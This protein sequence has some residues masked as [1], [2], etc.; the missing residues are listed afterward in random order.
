MKKT[1]LIGM[2]ALALISCGTLD[3]RREATSHKEIKEKV[4]ELPLLV[5]KADSLDNIP[6]SNRL[7][8]VTEEVFDEN[9]ASFTLH[10][11]L[12]NP[13]T[14]YL[15]VKTNIPLPIKVQVSFDLKGQNPDDTYIGVS[16][17]IT[18]SESP[19]IYEMDISN[20][21]VFNK[22]LPNG[23][24]ETEVKFYPN[25]G[26]EGGNKLAKQ[27]KVEVSDKG[28]NITLGGSKIS[29]KEQ[30]ER[31]KMQ[32]WVMNNVISS[33]VWDS[34]KF[35]QQLGSFTELVV[36]NR[37]SRVIKAYYFTKADMTIF[38]NVLKG[39]VATWRTGKEVTI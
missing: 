20:Y 6:V 30:G 33:T 37:N 12:K 1:I 11:E 13:T 39:K 9:T 16:E 31:D 18:L 15:A 2:L 24:Y 34:K 26:A 3:E 8:I 22:Q 36:T 4:K 19:F 10:A 5:E 21:S 35:V 17:S 25:W 29:S 32:R 23:V 38:V 27:I 28:P 14:A 7:P